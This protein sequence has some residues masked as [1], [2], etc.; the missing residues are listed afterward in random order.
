MLIVIVLQFVII[1][2]IN[3]IVINIPVSNNTYFVDS[4]RRE[5]FQQYKSSIDSTRTIPFEDLAKQIE[6]WNKSRK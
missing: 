4:T 5:L 6:Q 2:K 1:N 3:N